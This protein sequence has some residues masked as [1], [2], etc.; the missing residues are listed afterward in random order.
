[1][2]K[3][4]RGGGSLDDHA[5][6]DAGRV[7]ALQIDQTRT[8]LPAIVVLLID[9]GLGRVVPLIQRYPLPAPV[10]CQ[11]R[12][13]SGIFVFALDAELTVRSTG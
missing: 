6:N 4:G 8:L 11:C 13:D 1:M 2:D 12:C 3:F 10:D 9:Q 5:D 7:R